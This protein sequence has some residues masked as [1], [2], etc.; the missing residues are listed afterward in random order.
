LVVFRVVQAA[1]AALMTPTSLSMVLATSSGEGARQQRP[2]MDG[3]RRS[4]GGLGPVAGGLLVAIS[5]RWVFFANIPFGLAV[6]VV[7]WMRLPH[8][9]GE[10]IPYPDALGAALVTAGVALLTLGLV[11]GDD[12]GWG[13]TQT[14]AVLAA[15][16][17]VI[18]SFVLHCLHHRNPLVDPDLFRR[19]SVHGGVGRRDAVPGRVRRFPALAGALGSERLALVRAAHG[20]HDRAQP[21]PGPTDRAAAGR[22]AHQALRLGCRHRARRELLRVGMLWFALFAGLKPDYLVDFFPGLV[23]IGVGVGLTLPTMMAS[24][25]S[26]LAP[27]NFATGSAVVNMLRQVGLAIGVAVLVAVLGTPGGAHALLDAFDH[28]WLVI[29]AFAAP[30]RSRRW[31]SSGLRRPAPYAAPT[32]ATVPIDGRVALAEET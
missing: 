10:R 2:R 13:S 26:E 32:G 18:G 19:R 14:I 30:L 1:G 20:A 11:K 27:E 25:T 9:R 8:V 31:R 12:W 6:L 7:G 4:D 24:A 5:W 21:V 3:D 28:A 22:T 15:S 29:A 16:V 17:A 23:L